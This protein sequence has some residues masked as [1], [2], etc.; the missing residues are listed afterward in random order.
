[1]D[2]KPRNH[3]GKTTANPQSHTVL[4]LPVRVI[5]CYC[6]CCWLP[7]SHSVADCLFVPSIVGWYA[8]SSC[9]L[10][11]ICK[12]FALITIKICVSWVY[13]FLVKDLWF[14][15]TSDSPSH[16]CIQPATLQW[17]METTRIAANHNQRSTRHIAWD[18]RLSITLKLRYTKNLVT[19]KCL[20]P[21]RVHHHCLPMKMVSLSRALIV[22]H[23]ANPSFHMPFRFPCC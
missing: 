7:P 5:C 4:P 21:L 17:Q 6:Y 12:T 19:H 23:R 10:G 15:Y 18:C 9:T 20:L 13:L 22:K 2:K 14:C 11:C 8:Y 1:M 16:S 3:N